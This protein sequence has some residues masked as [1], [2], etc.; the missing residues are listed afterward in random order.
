MKRWFPLIIT[1]VFVAWIIGA[2]RVPKDRAGSFAVNE[3][4]RLPVVANGRFQ[5]LDSL[6]RNSILQLREKQRVNLE[7][8]KEWWQRPKMLS[9][10]EWLMEMTMNQ[11]VADTRPVFR[12][13]HP[14]LK[15]LLAL[16]AEAN[17][18]QQ[19]DGKHYS[20][21]QI[22][23][24]M[25]EFQEQLARASGV[26]D[27]KRNPFEKAVIRLGSGVGVYMRLQNTLQPQNS[28]DWNA[29]L[30][31]YIAAIDPGR[32][33]AIAQ[34]EGKQYDSAALEKLMRDLQ[35]IDAM[36]GLEMPNGPKLPLT[37]PPPDS[38][39]THN[40]QWERTGA[41]LMDIA[42]GHPEPFA[43]RSYAKMSSAFVN[44]DVAGF[45]SAVMEYRARLAGE[46][47]EQLQKGKSEQLFN[48]FEPFYRGMVVS[49]VAG[50]L[51]IAYWF[52]PATGDWLRRGAVW[53]ATLTWVVLSLGIGYRMFLEGR[54]PVTNLY[55]SAVFIGWGAMGLGLILELFWKNSIGVV[56]ASVCGFLC[57]IIAHHLALSGDT[58]EM[59]QAVLDT[60]FWLATHVVIVTLG[61]AST[62]VGG[63][64]AIV[65]ILRGFFSTSV[66]ASMSKAL[67]KMVYGII[68]F[69]ALFSFVGTVLGGIWA[70]QSWG[71]FWG[72][73]AKENGALIIVLWNALILHARW[74]GLVRERGLMNLTIFGN[75]VTAWSWFGVN[76]LGIGLHSY[77]F[78]DAAFKWLLLF[79][80]FCFLLNIVGAMPLRYWLS[81]SADAP[82]HS[83]ARRTLG[84][85]VLLLFGVQLFCV[86]QNYTA[87]ST[88]IFVIEA[89]LWFVVLMIAFFLECL[90]D[91]PRKPAL[92]QQE[93]SQPA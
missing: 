28:R 61:Y 48:F 40:H 52:V 30:D 91:S 51:A 70:D 81:F 54:P 60:N 15:A 56:I 74:G 22:T 38:D 69:A 1:A 31:N 79:V 66:D 73:D 49:V 80:G 8:W 50:L 36:L 35:R 47:Q 27:E 12:V 71:R 58:M 10:T 39:P 76:M 46:F 9:A 78:M 25:R 53:L 77:G 13:D 89:G 3:F 68:C 63:F 37:I 20:W 29:E 32:I 5:P 65:Y 14:D 18:A 16:P 19:T 86:L 93:L 90:G 88:V 57:L 7:P 64:L 26:A 87:V 21:N 59:L 85:T 41:A 92:P 75:V 23:P 82:A 42:R 45:N 55:S 84:W 72:W 83:A 2:W 17:A 62:F 67:A 24:K 34:N 6:A 44:G 43:I 33:A 4:G 11:Q